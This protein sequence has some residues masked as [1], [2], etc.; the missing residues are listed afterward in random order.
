MDRIEWLTADAA[1]GILKTN[2]LTV[3]RWIKSGGLPAYRVGAQW[4]IRR[5]ELNAWVKS[6]PSSGGAG[7]GKGAA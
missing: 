6:Q 5:D 3:L 2:Y 1:A 7:N 4:R